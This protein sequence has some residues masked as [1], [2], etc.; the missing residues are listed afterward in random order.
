MDLKKNLVQKLLIEGFI[1]NRKL[2]G[3]LKEQEKTKFV[4]CIPNINY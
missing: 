1:N 2:E 3:F 4:N